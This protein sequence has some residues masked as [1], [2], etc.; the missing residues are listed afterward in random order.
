[1]F[2]LESQ[3]LDDIG[4]PISGWHFSIWM[5][6]LRFGGAVLP[7]AV[8]VQRNFIRSRSIRDIYPAL[9]ITT[10]FTLWYFSCGHD[11]SCCNTS[12]ASPDSKGRRCKAHSS[13]GHPCAAAACLKCS[14]KGLQIAQWGHLCE[15]H[16]QVGWRGF[17]WRSSSWK[18]S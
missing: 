12:W 7:T 15:H 3:H 2:H 16:S 8:D 9:C 5:T 13:S 4:F 10:F 14:K 1:M 11:A 17:R 18:N 6:L